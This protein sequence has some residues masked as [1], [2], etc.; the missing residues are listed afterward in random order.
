MLASAVRVME[1]GVPEVALDVDGATEKCVAGKNGELPPP[2]PCRTLKLLANITTNR[3]FF[4]ALSSLL[5][6]VRGL[7]S[8]YDDTGF[9]EFT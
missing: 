1:N 5:F 3:A 8:S 7:C 6:R 9:V 2:Q 4:M